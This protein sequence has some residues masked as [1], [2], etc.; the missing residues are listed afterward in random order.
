[1]IAAVCDLDPREEVVEVLQR[2]PI[3]V[4]PV[5]NHA[6]RFIGVIR[7]AELMA[8]VEEETSLDIQTMVGADQ[9]ADGFSCRRRGRIVREHQ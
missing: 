1:M 8:A 9:P 5:V 7:Q 2:E 3:T 4:L 6:G